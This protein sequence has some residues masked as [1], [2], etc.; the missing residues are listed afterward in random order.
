MTEE[1]ATG[2]KTTTEKMRVKDDLIESFLN[3]RSNGA[4]LEIGLGEGPKIERLPILR[5]NGMKY[6]GVDFANVCAEHTRLIRKLGFGDMI[7]SG[8]IT[9]WG[10]TTG[11]YNYNLLKMLRQGLQFDLIYLDGH[12]TLQIDLPAAILATT[13]LKPDGLFA[14]DDIWWSLSKVARLMHDNFNL[15][16]YYKDAYELDRY[17]P[18]EIAD[19]GMRAIVYE[20]LIPHF[21]YRMVEALSN[22]G[23]VVLERAQTGRGLE[24]Q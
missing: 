18:E 8:A 14:L 21:G 2:G 23:W 24:L 5:K 11:T 22:P 3:S 9:F 16:M 13:L 17:E 7:D 1:A 12:H 19:Q 4:Y 6:V 15:W 10:N 20:I